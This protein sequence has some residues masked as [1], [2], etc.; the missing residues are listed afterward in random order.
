M[1]NNN[2]NQIDIPDN[3]SKLIVSRDKFYFENPTNIIDGGGSDSLNKN[4]FIEVLKKMNDK[5]DFKQNLSA[6][7]LSSDGFNLEFIQNFQSV[8]LYKFKYKQEYILDKIYDKHFH[9]ITNASS[10]INMYEINKDEIY[11]IENV[12][13]DDRYKLYFEFLLGNT[14]DKFELYLKLSWNYAAT[15]VTTVTTVQTELIKWNNFGEK[16]NLEALYNIIENNTPTEGNDL[17]TFRSKINDDI[18]DN[19]KLVDFKELFKI[20]FKYLEW[21]KKIEKNKIDRWEV[22]I[23]AVILKRM[24]LVF[25][26]IGDQ[27]QILF[28]RYLNE[29]G[30]FKDKFET[31]FTTHDNLAKI[32]AC[33]NQVSN[34]SM[35]ENN[36]P[37]REYCN[38]SPHGM[39]YY[40]TIYTEA[41][42]NQQDLQSVSSVV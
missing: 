21:H 12:L 19:T 33:E 38:S 39:T 15:T 14:N 11:N 23:I 41:T 17:R 31:L 7:N 16:G 13:Y 37:S 18:D 30:G 26:L 4:D 40:N 32:Y 3:A 42:S 35:A 25:K 36:V 6:F 22:N 1:I 27:G 29:L 2:Y 10:S 8:N 5:M 24:M 9:K 34:V 28:V 20:V